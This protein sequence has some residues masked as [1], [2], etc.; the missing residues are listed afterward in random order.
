MDVTDVPAWLTAEVIAVPLANLLRTNVRSIPARTCRRL[1]SGAG[2]ALGVW[3]LA[4]TAVVG[5]TMREWSLILKGWTPPE[6]SEGAGSQRETALYRS[7]LLDALPA[8]IRAPASYGEMEHTDGTIWIWFEDIVDEEAG[9]WSLDRYA[10]AARHLGRF[11]GAYLTGHPLPAGPEIGRG[12]LRQWVDSAAEAIA[13]VEHASEQPL[14]R[15]AYP[16]H[17]AE[18]YA[19]LWADRQAHHALLD[20]LPQTF[21]HLDAFKRNLLLTHSPD[22]EEEIVAIDWEFAGVGA[23]GE[24]LAPLVIASAI[25]HEAPPVALP[26]FEATVL[27]S[28]I[29]GLRDVGWGGDPA[30]VWT[31]Y[32]TAAVMR[33]GVGAVS[34]LLPFLLDDRPLVDLERFIG[35]PWQV[36][37]PDLL[38]VNEHLVA[39]ADEMTR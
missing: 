20:R 17:V 21:C 5:D 22:G 10:T 11:N 24:E 16:P 18:V 35:H 3:R 34:R 26:A 30:T 39:V 38:A 12:W 31:G 2:T 37:L 29:D 36:I 13:H 7:G 14:V 19:R 27:G 23:I 9:P 15:R 32:R 6:R 8:G 33:Y 4:G 1:T 25:F 28:Y